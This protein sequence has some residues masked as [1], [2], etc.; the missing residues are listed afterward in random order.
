MGRLANTGAD[1]DSGLAANVWN[2]TEPFNDAQRAFHR[3][4]MREVIA[5]LAARWPHLDLFASLSY[6]A[7]IPMLE[8]IDFTGFGA[9]DLHIWAVHHP[10]CSSATNYYADMHPLKNDIGFVKCQDSITQWWKRDRKE[11]LAWMDNQLGLVAEAGRKL[12]I[13]TGNTEGWGPVIWTE[14]PVLTWDFVKEAGDSCVELA[15]KHGQ[16]FICT[17]NFTHPQFPG[18]WQDVAWHQRLTGLIRKGRPDTSLATGEN[19]PERDSHG[20]TREALLLT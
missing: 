20:I 19:Q 16:K 10:S 4:F 2:V 6:G 17:S 15:L 9:L 3:G 8:E 11:I 5:R 7:S 1:G 18:L 12:G 13:P 14:H